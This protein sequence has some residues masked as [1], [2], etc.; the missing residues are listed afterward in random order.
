MW[1]GLSCVALQCLSTAVVFL[2][3]FSCGKGCRRLVTLRCPSTAVVIYYIYQ[4]TDFPEFFFVIFFNFYLSG[5]V[6]ILSRDGS[7][8]GDHSQKYCLQGH[9]CSK[10][11]GH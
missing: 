11:L 4:G 9:L 2:L 7:A 10:L 3:F 6:R 5:A 8:S 1:Q